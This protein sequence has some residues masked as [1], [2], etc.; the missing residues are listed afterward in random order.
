MIGET[1]GRSREEAALVEESTGRS[2]EEASLDR[3]DYRLEQRGGS[4][5]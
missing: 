4:S 3:R 2:R 1:T 5:C